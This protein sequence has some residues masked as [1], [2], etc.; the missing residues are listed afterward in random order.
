MNFNEAVIEG[1]APRALTDSKDKV[2]ELK[3]WARPPRFQ[4]EPTKR[5]RCWARQNDESSNFKYA[6]GPQERDPSSIS[7]AAVLR[8][9]TVRKMSPTAKT[10][11]PR[12]LTPKRGYAEKTQNLHE[13]KESND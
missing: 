3:L 12:K 13:S 2:L 1:A 6:M 9:W 10:P 8:K 4:R 11:C 7:W 5:I